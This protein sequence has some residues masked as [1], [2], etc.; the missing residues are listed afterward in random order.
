M[1]ISNLTKKYDKKIVLNDINITFNKSCSLLLGENGSGK[2]TFFLIVAG[3]IKKYSGEIDVKDNVSLLLDEPNLFKYKTGIENL[4]YF[5]LKEEKAVALEYVSYFS[6]DNYINSRVSTYSNG[7][8]KK[9]SLVIALSRNKEILLLDEPTNSLDFS[10]ISLLKELLIKLKENKIVLIS[11]HDIAIYDDRL[12]DEVYLLKK[13]KINLIESNL[14]NYYYYKVKTVNPIE[15]MSF[16]FQLLE[17][18]Y[19]FKVPKKE[20]NEFSKELGQYLIKEMVLVDYFDPIYLGDLY[21]E[22]A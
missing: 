18:N 5:L 12:I 14:F 11:S 8:K 9:L 22:N 20:F 10:S 13:G 6:M 19:I 2:T 15:K 3:I 4:D 1:Q 7:M 16:E 21:E 17:D